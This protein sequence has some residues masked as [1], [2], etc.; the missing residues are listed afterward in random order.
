MDDEGRDVHGMITRVKTFGKRAGLQANM[1]WL[2]TISTMNPLSRKHKPSVFYQTVQDL[3]T[4][5]LQ[6]P[7]PAGERPDLLSHFVATHNAQP[8]LMDEHQ[9]KISAS[10]NLIAGAL[11]PGSTF[12]CLFRFLLAEPEAQ[13]KLYSE[14]Q[15]A[16]TSTPVQFDEVKD[17]PY[18]KGVIR[19]AERLHQSSSFNLQRV[20]G[21]EGL[22]LPNGVFL[23]PKANVGC[24]AQAT[25]QDTRVFG[26]DASI[27]RPERWMRQ[28][29]EDEQMYEERIKLMDRVDLS[30]GQGSR[31]CIGKSIFRLEVFKALAT[32]TVRFKVNY[33]SFGRIGMEQL[34]SSQFEKV[35]GSDSTNLFVRVQ[36]RA[37]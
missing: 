14:L 30:F 2:Y 19:E 24:P 31:T 29:G 32:L 21:P 4:S 25:N 5:R 37:K 7:D 35:S 28:K 11:S 6:H 26:A 22:K 18:L 8:R 20:V 13:A 3:V 10:G 12:D 17:L 36:S 9:V 16:D 27:Y 34:T 1:P 33:P 23:P 15:S